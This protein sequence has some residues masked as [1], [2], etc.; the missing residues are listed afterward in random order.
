M[1]GHCVFLAQNE[2]TAGSVQQDV[3]LVGATDGNQSCTIENVCTALRYEAVYRHCRGRLMQNSIA[4]IGTGMAGLAAARTLAEAGRPVQL[5]DK[6]RGS[7]GRMASRRSEMGGLD[8]GAQYFTA[9]DP[10]FQQ[11]VTRWQANGWVSPWAPSLYAQ[12]DGSPLPA[13]DDQLRWIGVPRMSALT[14]ALLGELPVTFGCR[15]IEIQPC[16]GQW[17]LLDDQGRQH[18]PFSQV[19]VAIP[20]PQASE[21]LTVAPALAATAAS[22]AMQ[23][24]WAVALGFSQPL[25]TAMQ[26]CFVRAPTLDWFARSTSK[27]GRSSTP[28]SW[29][30][31]ASSA[32]SD[33]HQALPAERV[34]R[35]LSEA[36]AAA[37]DCPLPTADVSL[38]HLWRY[39]RPARAQ[40]LG[41]LMDPALGLY[42]CGDW[43]LSGRIE[44]AWL[45]GRHAALALLA[46]P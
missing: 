3:P 19:I 4:I 7:G 23:A 6:S 13:P 41:A 12:R 1:I 25:P 43:C 36:F 46:T 9:R 16:A 45:S 27:A 38:A 10:Q 8:L 22:V 32:W 26:A 21:L 34:I 18:G 42:A 44:G 20:A 24:T 35:Q 17:R 28:D 2:G 40:T 5:F 14:R 11:A 31:H 33:E 15:I 37:L 39:A 29:V 30:L